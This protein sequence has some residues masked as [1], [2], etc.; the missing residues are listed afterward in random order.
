MLNW[1]TAAFC[2][3]LGLYNLG[4]GIVSEYA[5]V[6]FGIGAAV[7]FALAAMNVWIA[8]WVAAQ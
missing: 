6:A 3:A 5:S 2:A 4:R 1:M 8:L 7:C